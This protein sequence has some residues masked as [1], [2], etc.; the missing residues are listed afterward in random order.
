LR[1]SSPKRSASRRV[2]DNRPG[3]GATLGDEPGVRA[4]PDAY[5][6]TL[7]TPSYSINPS[8]HTR[9]FDAVADYTPIFSRS[10]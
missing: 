7:I 5:T 8:L 4:A 6:L 9:K 10:S 2:V 1:R 3:G